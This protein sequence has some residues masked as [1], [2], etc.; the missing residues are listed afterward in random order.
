MNEKA[1]VSKELNAKHKKILEGLLKLPENRE[2][3]DCK[4]KGPRWASVNLGIFICMQCSGIH[5]SLGVHIS[6]VRS[7]TLDTWLPEQ[8]AFIQSMGNEKSNSYWEAELPPNYDRVGIENFIRAKY[9]EKRWIPRDGKAKTSGVQEERAS[10]YRQRPV[11]KGGHGHANNVEHS[12]MERKNPTPSSTKSNPPPIKSS[13]PAPPK[14]SEQAPPDPKPE[15]AVQKPEPVVQKAEPTTQAVNSTVVPPPKVDYA[16]DLF[17]MLS[18]ES[19]N[20]NGRDTSS[21]DDNGWAGFQSAETSS[22]TDNVSPAKPVESKTPSG[23]G[24][25]DLFKDSPS[26]TQP[27]NSD[28]P[29]KDV[30]N[31]I[32]SLFD[33]SNI[34]SPFS[35]HQQQLAMLAQQQSLLM[36]AA[37]K[38]G[39]VAPIFPGNTHQHV[40]P[41]SNGTHVPGNNLPAQNWSNASYQVPGMTMPVAGQSDLQKFMQAGHIRPTPPAGSSVSYPAPSM[42]TMGSVAPSNGVITGGL[43]RPPSVSSVSSVT[44]TQS[45]KDYDFSSLTQ[46]LFSKP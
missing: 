43:N 3:A 14:A 34:V 5:R 16:T 45:G 28:K 41:V 42:Y 37:A 44:P 4:S 17:N 13:I 24:I 39:S 31:D 15:S 11:D 2:C 20:A 12:S 36:A 9:E 19:P 6:K 30:K 40:T 10:A 38:S 7:A 33:K 8:V 22:T 35:V 18:M 29:Q 26:V 23:S 21:I 27:P 32:M 1:N 46:G 25:E